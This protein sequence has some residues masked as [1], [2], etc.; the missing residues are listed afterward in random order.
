MLLLLNC[1]DPRIEC[2]YRKSRNTSRIQ[3]GF[4]LDCTDI[5]TGASIQ[6]FTVWYGKNLDVT[7]DGILLHCVADVNLSAEPKPLRSNCRKRRMT[8]A[9]ASPAG[10]FVLAKLEMGVE[11]NLNLWGDWT[12]ANTDTV[13]V[14]KRTESTNID[15]V[16]STGSVLFDFSRWVMAYQPEIK[17]ST[18]QS[19]GPSF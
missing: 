1:V 6:G 15:A 11:P 7:R 18:N 5:E 19:I 13:I 4:W 10:W 14:I 9:G 17:R 16:V 2:E 8:V 3:A 12:E